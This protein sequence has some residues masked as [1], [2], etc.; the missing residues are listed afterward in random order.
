MAAHFFAGLVFCQLNF[1]NQL[2]GRSDETGAGAKGGVGM[3]GWGQGRARWTRG[4]LQPQESSSEAP[5]P[6]PGTLQGG[7][8]PRSMLPSVEAHQHL[9]WGRASSTSAF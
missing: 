2:T 7:A 6:Q 8:L 9:L 5:L 4:D 3:G 1:L